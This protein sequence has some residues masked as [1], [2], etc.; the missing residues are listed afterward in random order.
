MNIPILQKLRLRELVTCPEVT[1]L[2]LKAPDFFS[3]S[4]PAHPT[5]SHCA[6]EMACMSWVSSVTM[7]RG[8]G[9]S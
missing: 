9:V 1:Y 8:T 7:A 5:F 2:P 6:S 4:P 3:A